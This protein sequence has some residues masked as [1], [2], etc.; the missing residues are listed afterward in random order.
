[1]SGEELARR[2][3]EVLADVLKKPSRSAEFHGFEFDLDKAEVRDPKSWMDLERLSGSDAFKDGYFYST[4]MVPGKAPKKGGLNA[5]KPALEFKPPKDR[6]TPVLGVMVP[7]KDYMEYLDWI[8]QLEDEKT[9][10]SLLPKLSA[11]APQHQALAR[12][13]PRPRQKLIPEKEKTSFPATEREE[14]PDVEIVG[15]IQPSSAFN[16]AKNTNHTVE[17]EDSELTQSSGK[18]RARTKAAS[19]TVQ[20]L[21]QEQFRNAMKSGDNI[22]VYLV[23]VPAIKEVIARQKRMND[24]PES[25]DPYFWSTFEEMEVYH[26]TISIAVHEYQQGSFKTAHEATILSGPQALI[27]HFSRHK[28]IAKRPYIYEERVLTRLPVTDELGDI[29]NEC[30]ILIWASALLTMMY[31]YMDAV[32]LYEQGSLIRSHLMAQVPPTKPQSR[33]FGARKAFR[34]QKGISPS[35][36]LAYLLEEKIEG[37]FVKYI[38]NGEPHPLLAPDDPE[39]PVAEFLCFTQHV[40]YIQT[41]KS[42]F[43]SDYQGAGNRLTDPQILTHHEFSLSTFGMGNIAEGFIDFEAKHQCN[44]YCEWFELAPFEMEAIIG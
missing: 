40:Q 6:D 26:G 28:I 22:V 35:I 36:R 29:G 24:Q 39:Y 21:D 18:S 10:L 33:H 43:I 25:S 9:T 34:S 8:A 11:S 30:N 2:G 17:S 13:K 41:A 1:M 12:P 3:R 32:R 27:D 5:A 14:S 15:H 19:V 4:V 31:D 37:N 38:H 44:H 7:Y 20:P 16:S 23:P 42:A